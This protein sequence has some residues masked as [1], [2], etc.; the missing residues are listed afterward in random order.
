MIITA[1]ATDAIVSQVRAGKARTGTEG[2]APPASSSRRIRSAV[3]HA[4]NGCRI[5]SVGYSVSAPPRCG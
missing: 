4:G 3:H 5:V 1:S 2:L